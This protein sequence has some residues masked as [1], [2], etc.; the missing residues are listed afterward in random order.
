MRSKVE[1][2]KVCVHSCEWGLAGVFMLLNIASAEEWSLA[3]PNITA[4]SA[5]TVRGQMATSNGS[6][7]LLAINWVGTVSCVNQSS[8]NVVIR[9]CALTSSNKELA[10]D[11]NHHNM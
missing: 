6:M 5:S 7:I 9:Y 8:V 4:S 11:K 3:A 1:K 10:L 2:S